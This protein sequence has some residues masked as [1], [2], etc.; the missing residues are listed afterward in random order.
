[1][2]RA[3]LTAALCMLLSAGLATAAPFE[4]LRSRESPEHAQLILAPREGARTAT[5][6]VAFQ[7]G[8]FDEA[9]SHG[10]TRLTQHAMLEANRRGRYDD[11]VRDLFGAGASLELVTGLRQSAFILEVHH[12]DFDRLAQRL[13][14]MLL[15][16]RLD[17]SKLEQA[18]ERTAQDPGLT[19]MHDFLEARLAS[20]LSSDTRYAA[21]P[22]PFP[23]SVQSLTERHVAIH[24]SS[25]FTP[26]N[27]TVIAAGAFDAP[28]L[29]RAVASYRG[30][31][32]A[33]VAR[34]TPKLPS[35]ARLPAMSDVNVLAY[36]V[37]ITQPE[38]AAV[39][40]VVGPL[41]QRRMERRFRTMGVGYAQEAAPMLTPWMDAL[42]LTL[43]ANDPSALD[44]GPFL[45][46]EVAAV[47]E[48]RVTPEEYATSHGAALARLRLEDPNPRAVALQLASSIQTPAWYSP[49]VETSLAALSAEEFSRRVQPWLSESRL[50]H[51]LF[52]PYQTPRPASK[53]RIRG[54]GRR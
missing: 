33:P 4:V 37:H 39:L 48:G 46:Q 50:V 5:L 12:R 6:V 43:P 19:D 10:L 45:L 36:P 9:G 20:A 51:L 54:G 25:A 28:A 29:R 15:D 8:R 18:I 23:S 38:E 34:L 32:A 22:P 16:A 40:R 35:K 13:L 2:K 53:S 14:G 26:R 41:L 52:T 7:S 21:P 47:R 1:M 49:E 27:A 3:S 24:M 11:L 31:I 17:A 44:L 42:V 30:G